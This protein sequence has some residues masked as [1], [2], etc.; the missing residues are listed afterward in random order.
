MRICHGV[1]TKPVLPSFTPSVI[2]EPS[3]IE[4]DLSPTPR[5]VANTM[6]SDISTMSSTGSSRIVAGASVAATTQTIG[7][8]TRAF[9]AIASRPEGC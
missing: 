7:M 9:M 3:L 8:T 1:R 6:R 2:L 5:T 4:T